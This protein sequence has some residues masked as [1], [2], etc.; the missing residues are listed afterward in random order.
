V[1]LRGIDWGLPGALS[2]AAKLACRVP[3]A[4]GEK[5]TLMAQV[6]FGERTVGS[7]QFG[8]ATKSEG[9]APVTRMEVTLSACPPVLVR[10]TILELLDCP[11]VMAP[12][13]SE[14]GKIAATDPLTA[15]TGVPEM[16]SVP[17]ATGPPNGEPGSSERAPL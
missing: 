4:V 15:C 10:V 16:A 9:F 5:T 11:T 2:A 8:V 1:P 14:A 12:K 6:A 17:C 3:A 13:S 7:E